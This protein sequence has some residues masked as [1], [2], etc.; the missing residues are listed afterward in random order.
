M[1]KVIKKVFIFDLGYT[2]IKHD[3]KIESKFLADK[4]RIKLTPEFEKEIS[5][6]WLQT[7][8]YLKGK[9]VNEKEFIEIA[10]KLVPTLKE[11]KKSGDTFLNSLY[12]MTVV[13]TYEY[14]EEILKRIKQSGGIIIGLSDWFKNDQIRELQEINLI[15]YFDEV[16]G[17][18][19]SYTKPHRESIGKILKKYN[20]YNKNEFIMIGNSLD[21][22]IKAAINAGIDSIWINRKD[23][24]SESIKPTYEIVNLKEIEEIIEGV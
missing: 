6:F 9:K 18:D 8:K 17:W 5:N 21:N 13:G 16:F 10:E 4:M 22:D 19:N 12:G 11:N 2:I 7:S 20:Q 24:K 14:S 3:D 15:D 23:E 1:K